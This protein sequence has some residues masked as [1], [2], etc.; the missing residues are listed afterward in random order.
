MI[1]CPRLPLVLAA[2]LLADGSLSEEI[3]PDLLHL[4][5]LGYQKWADAIHEKVTALLAN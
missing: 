5:P 1:S 2:L 4:S 3:M